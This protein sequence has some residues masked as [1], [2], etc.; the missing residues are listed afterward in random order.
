MQTLEWTFIK[1]PPVRSAVVLA[2]GGRHTPW[3]IGVS[4]FERV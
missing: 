3:Q 4:V 2:A 1:S